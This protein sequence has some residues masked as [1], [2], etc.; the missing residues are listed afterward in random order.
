MPSSLLFL[1]HG[2]HGFFIRID[3]DRA[4]RAID[5]GRHVVDVVVE[6]CARA[7][8]GSDAQG[9]GQDGR[10]RVRAAC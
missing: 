7:D 2:R 8:D 1:L 9:A 10:M 6:L 5:D 3:V 4:R